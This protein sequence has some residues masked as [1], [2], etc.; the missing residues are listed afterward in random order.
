MVASPPSIA[1]QIAATLRGEIAEGSPAIGQ[2]L[3]SESALAVRFGVSRVTVNR[4][5]TELRD[6]GLVEVR[7][8]VD[9]RV[10]AAVAPVRV[11]IPADV[12]AEVTRRAA[13]VGEP[14]ER[15]AARVLREAAADPGP[16]PP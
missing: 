8:G 5:L 13:A 14:P 2:A 12:W 10:V 9:T 6:E 1:A 16:G 3:P 4:A 15:W 7:R 11:A